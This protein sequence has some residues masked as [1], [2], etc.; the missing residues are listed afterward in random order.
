MDEQKEANIQKRKI[1]Q[2]ILRMFL[3]KANG[4]VSR[5]G[6]ILRVMRA[7]PSFQYLTRFTT[8]SRQDFIKFSVKSTFINP[9]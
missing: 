1:S 2:R 4:V 9:K 8:T 7:D 6:K 5:D 3:K